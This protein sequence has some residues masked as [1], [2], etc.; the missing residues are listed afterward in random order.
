MSCV[1]KIVK[2]FITFGLTSVL[3]L[4]SPTINSTPASANFSFTRTVIASGVGSSSSTSFDIQSV[5]GQPTVATEVSSSNYKLAVGFLSISDADG[6][7]VLDNIDNCINSINPSQLDTDF[8]GDGDACDSDDDNDGLSDTEESTLGTNPLLADTDNDGLDDF[9]E[10]NM[11]GNPL[12]YQVGVDTDPLNNDT[13]GD[14]LLDGVDPNP[15][16]AIPDG[17]LA[18]WGAPDGVINAADLL[19]AQRIALGLITAT[20]LDLAHGD[21]YPVGAP[22]GVI[23]VQDLILINVLVNP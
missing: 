9:T 5:I 8:N 16:T 21:V 1:R 6:D 22:D 3:G 11:D 12:D 20:P 19:I 13:D 17:D 2:K 4:V 18:P 23:N 10:T 15:L 14:G 7:A